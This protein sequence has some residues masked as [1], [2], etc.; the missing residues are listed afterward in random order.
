MCVCDRI[1][2]INALQ[3]LDL[4]TR[5]NFRPVWCFGQFVARNI[6]GGMLTTQLDEEAI[7]GFI[8]DNAATATV[9]SVAQAYGITEDRAKALWT[10]ATSVR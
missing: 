10:E 8:A 3:S 9:A 2:A 5:E 1:R 6:P 7:R 4:Q